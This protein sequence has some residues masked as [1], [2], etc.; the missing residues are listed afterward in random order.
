MAEHLSGCSNTVFYNRIQTVRFAMKHRHAGYL[1]GQLEA[2]LAWNCTDEQRRCWPLICTNLTAATDSYNCSHRVCACRFYNRQL[3][4]A[5]S[6]LTTDKLLCECLLIYL[7][8]I[9]F[10]SL[11]SESDPT[12]PLR[13]RGA[14]LAHRFQWWHIIF[15]DFYEAAKEST[16]L[17]T[18]KTLHKREISTFQDLHMAAWDSHNSFVTVERGAH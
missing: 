13:P 12:A 1:P 10:T 2:L 9:Y 11:R 18:A 5:E 3:Q 6:C 17:R 14:L 15:Y 7:L 4:S 16:R 8:H